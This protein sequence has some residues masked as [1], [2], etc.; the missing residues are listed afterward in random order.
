MVRYIGPCFGVAAALVV[1]IGLLRPA[2]V[3]MVSAISAVLLLTWL[4][5]FAVFLALG[6]DPEVTDFELGHDGSHR[7][8]DT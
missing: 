7:A 4:A 2:P 8:V 1:A 6:G 5:L 3:V